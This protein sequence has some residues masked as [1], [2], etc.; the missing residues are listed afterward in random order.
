MFLDVLSNIFLFALIDLAGI[1]WDVM[2]I[3]RKPNPYRKH[4]LQEASAISDQ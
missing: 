2:E 1:F 3:Y 4:R